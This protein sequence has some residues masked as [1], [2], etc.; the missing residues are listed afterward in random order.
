MES[1]FQ[2][3]GT[4]LP[5]PHRQEEEGEYTGLLRAATAAASLHQLYSSSAAD[6]IYLTCCCIPQLHS[7]GTLL[8]VTTHPHVG[9][10]ISDIRKDASS[11]YT[12]PSI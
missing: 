9:Y 10:V 4:H 12:S 5:S 8:T 6:L 2:K 1:E 3:H 11:L 7:G